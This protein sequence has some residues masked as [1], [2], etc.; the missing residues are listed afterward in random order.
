MSCNDEL[1]IIKC[2]S[3]QKMDYFLQIKTDL[4]LFPDMLLLEREKDK[5]IAIV[6]EYKPRPSKPPTAVCP[7][8]ELLSVRCVFP[9]EA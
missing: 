8:C 1:L 7:P 6:I 4:R 5:V 9:G 3:V 2:S